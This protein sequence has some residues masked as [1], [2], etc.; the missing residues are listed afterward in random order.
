M[1]ESLFDAI[2]S[3]MIYHYCDLLWPEKIGEEKF[4][5]AEARLV[6]E[7]ITSG[8]DDE[9]SLY[10]KYCEMLEEYVGERLPKGWNPTYDFWGAR[11]YSTYGHGTKIG[12]YAG[13]SYSHYMLFDSFQALKSYTDELLEEIEE[14]ENTF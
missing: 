2:C 1:Y 13:D 11:C 3:L 14:M 6:A 4:A 10:D 12:K 8:R 7:K 5:A 9:G